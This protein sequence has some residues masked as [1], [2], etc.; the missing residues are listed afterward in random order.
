MDTTHTKDTPSW[1]RSVRGGDIDAWLKLDQ[2]Q[3]TQ[4]MMV[5]VA[6]DAFKS[7]Q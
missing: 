3:Q 4:K 1:L 5:G 7:K 2:W 6:V